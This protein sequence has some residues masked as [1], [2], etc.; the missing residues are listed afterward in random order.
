MSE[1]K[2]NA[3]FL[4]RFLGRDYT[5]VSF[6]SLQ[7]STSTID[8]RIGEH[9]NVNYEEFFRRLRLDPRMTKDIRQPAGEFFGARFG[10][11]SKGNPPTKATKAI[12]NATMLWLWLKDKYVNVKLSRNN[13]HVTGC[14]K[15]EH[16]AEAARYIQMWLRWLSN[17]ASQ[18]YEEE[19]VIT[20]FAAHL[21]NYNFTLDVALDLEEFDHFQHEY[22]SHR[23]FSP[24]DKNISPTNTSIRCPEYQLAFNINDNGKVSMC[25]S[26]E[27]FDTAHL[28]V[29]LGYMMFYEMLA[30]F[31]ASRM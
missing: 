25:V 26:H 10:D 17:E 27:N 21:I 20:G 1:Q 15:A 2:K 14:K 28:N 24:Y 12:K 8:C 9:C 16:A 23:V 7:I 19:P 11:E 30:A 18:L 5:R 4:N 13:I 3:P 31:T 22:W 29:C 6:D